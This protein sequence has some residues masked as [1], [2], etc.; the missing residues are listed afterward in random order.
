MYEPKGKT[1]FSN[2]IEIYTIELDHWDEVNIS[3][4]YSIENFI[5]GNAL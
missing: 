2:Y 3:Y 4:E 5:N 1:K